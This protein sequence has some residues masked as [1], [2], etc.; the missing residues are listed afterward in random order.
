MS[1]I[2]RMT[3]APTP[4]GIPN[5]VGKPAWW[6]NAWIVGLLMFCCAPIGLVLLWLNPNWSTKNK[7]I[8]TAVVAGL[9]VIG[10]AMGGLNSPTTDSSGNPGISTEKPAPA[11]DDAT[12]DEPTPEPKAE[13]TTVSE[14]SGNTN[15]VGSDFHLKGCDTRL[16]YH[17]TGAEPLLAGIYVEESGKDLMKDGGFPVASPDKPGDGETVLHK[18]EGDY[19][20]QV[21]AANV[22]WTVQVQEKC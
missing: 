16:T 8:V 2:W 5:P 19:Y 3:H 21:V 10:F 22:D 11:E 12:Q 17:L 14:L 6:H 20:I 9:V 13:W 18:D 4:V 7:G 1:S 15:K